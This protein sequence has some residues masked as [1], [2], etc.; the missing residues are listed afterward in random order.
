[1]QQTS[2]LDL[3]D[4]A[5]PW[6]TETP[7]FTFDAVVPGLYQGDFPAGTVDWSRFDDVV[8]LTVEEVPGVQ[9]RVG[10]LRMHVPIWDDEMVNPTGVRAAALTVAERVTAGKRVL[11]HC[12]AGLNR[13][14]VV[15]A[16]ALM[17]MGMPVA[18]AIARVRSARG[19]YALSNRDFVAWLHEEVAAYD[20][21]AAA[22]RPERPRRPLRGGD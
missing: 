4:D 15:S 9:L 10:G 2:D 19:P 12:W 5:M 22:K 8:S 16:R 18:E 7:A 13:S 14:G 17:F 3:L 21:G 11:V 6:I 1:M 20:S